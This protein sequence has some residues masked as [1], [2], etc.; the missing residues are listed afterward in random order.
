[1]VYV[2]RDI[3]IGK[4]ILIVKLL[5]SI[6]F[7]YTIVDKGWYLQVQMVLYL[8]FWFSVFSDKNRNTL[9]VIMLSSFL[10]MLYCIILFFWGMSST[11]YE[12]VSPFILGM[13]FSSISQNY[14]HDI[15]NKTYIFN[16]I[17]M[18]IFFVIFLI[19]G[20][21]HYLPYGFRIISKSLSSCIFCFLIFIIVH[22]VNVNNIVTEFIGKYSFPIYAFQGIFLKIYKNNIVGNNIIYNILYCIAVITTTIAFSIIIYPIFISVLS[23]T[24]TYNNH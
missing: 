8:I 23:K 4:N 16:M 20:N 17:L 2:I 5:K 21:K 18:M 24:K 7:G 12:S 11:W 13:I 10:V 9:Y 14:Y 1:M 19:L 15:K 22:V 6:M 3:V